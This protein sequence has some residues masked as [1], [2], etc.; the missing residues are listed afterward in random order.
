MTQRRVRPQ[1]TGPNSGRSSARTDNRWVTADKGALA[2]ELLA[3]FEQHKPEPASFP[4]M[5]SRVIDLVEHPDVDV[6]RLAHV[7]ER[8]PA[9]CAAVLAVA[10][11]AAN[12]RSSPVQA[13]RTATTLL[14][15]KRVANI[16]V[17]IA[18]RSLFDVELR[19][20]HE[21]F[22]HWWSRLFHASMTE[23]FAASF[24]AMERMH[25]ASEGI[26]LAG[27]LHNIGASLALRS[28]ATL[29]IGGSLPGV[30]DESTIEA[31]LRSTRVPIGV[32]ALTSFQLP[33][34]QIQICLTQTAE[35]VPDGPEWFDTHIIR[36]V[37]AL[38]ELRM[39]TLD[40]AE[41]LRLLHDS[42]AALGL[43]PQDV[44][45]IAKQLSEHA[46][47]VE[48]LF[49]TT[50]GSDETGFLEFLERTL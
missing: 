2:S 44:V 23:A 38:N 1:T 46:A 20:Q 8:D 18:C 13:I 30:P 42:R 28:L 40:T 37:S 39:G 45:N 27:M 29:I 11:S 33:Q 19:V 34:S 7:I 36:L 3:Y 21:L 48:L 6:A 17:G 43:V 5:A 47:Q 22:P 41:P 50:D 26:F 31:V 12:R 32:M 9:I 49:S 15:L 35:V 25:H 10:N 16:A 24:V 4:A 14:G